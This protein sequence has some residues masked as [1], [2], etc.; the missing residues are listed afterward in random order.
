MTPE[1]VRHAGRPNRVGNLGSPL[2]LLA[3]RP[4]D[5]LTGVGVWRS[6]VAHLHGVQGVAGSNP[7][8]PTIYF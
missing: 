8:T 6:L 4:C 2:S 1:A 7:V 3:P 5:M